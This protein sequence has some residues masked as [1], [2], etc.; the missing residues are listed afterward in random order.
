MIATKPE[1]LWTGRPLWLDE[2]APVPPFAPCDGDL[3]CDVAVVGAGI[4][5]AVVAE[6]LAREGHDVLMLDRRGP[7]RGSTIASTALLQAE[8]DMPMLLM[9]RRL[10]VA[11]ADAAWRRS[12]LALDALAARIRTLGI[13]CGLCEKPVLYLPGNVLSAAQLRQ[14]A[15]LRRA[16]GLGAAM[17]DKDI[18]QAGGIAATAALLTQGAYEAHPGRLLAGMLMAAK[19]QGARLYA[20]ESVAEVQA[21]PRHVLLRLESGSTVRASHVVF[22]TGYEVLKGL[23]SRPYRLTSS[24]AFATAPQPQNIWWQGAQIW[25]ATDP[26]LYIRTTPD[27]RVICGGEDEDTDD[28]IHRACAMPAKVERLR[29][30]LARLLPEVD[31][32]PAACWAGCFGQTPRGLPMIGRVPGLARCL[33]VMAFGG[34]GITFSQIGADM[35]ANMIAGRQDADAALFSLA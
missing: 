30:K 14:E 18:L 17:A 6:A 15:V 19:S 20:P 13:D 24:W 34:N 10:G 9:R 4:T 26:Y 33:A 28:P 5:G 32:T 23:R 16:A 21:H 31:T 7:L 35:A 11:A 12:R 1:N 29:R 2:P 25:Q 8:L 3:R 27:G 22:A